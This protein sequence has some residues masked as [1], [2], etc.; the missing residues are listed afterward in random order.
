M[1]FDISDFLNSCDSC[2]NFEKYK[3]Q[4]QKKEKPD[5]R[6]NVLCHDATM[7]EKFRLDSYFF[8]TRLIDDSTT[9]DISTAP[10]YTF[11]TNALFMS[12]CYNIIT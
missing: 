6:F 2:C 8:D 3:D 11:L 1:S 4:K 7:D 12:Y 9:E 5:I 10:T